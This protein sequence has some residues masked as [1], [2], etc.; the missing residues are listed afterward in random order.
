MD[1]LLDQLEVKKL[2]QEYS[3]LLLDEEYKEKIIE[4][5]R[6]E[7]LSEVG[8]IATL[9]ENS[10]PQ[11]SVSETLNEKI[12][13]STIDPKTKE[14][15]KKLYREIV[16]LTHPDKTDLEGLNQLYLKAT[17][18]SHQ[19]D[20]FTLYE[21]C[22]ELK[23]THSVDPNDKEILK[24]KIN[25]KKAKLKTIESSYI[26]LYVNSKTEEE[27]LALINQFAEKHGKKI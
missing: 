13:L 23:I 3:F 26:W 5:N 24:T 21:I 1:E 16:K 18:A 4:L 9:G 20:L 14:K 15:V 10:Q 12:D 11:Q 6:Q 2:L 17:L 19:F 25:N 7:F 8:K 22:S 27:K